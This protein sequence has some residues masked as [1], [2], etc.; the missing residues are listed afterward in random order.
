MENYINS[1]RLNNDF[2]GS[3]ENF[4]KEDLCIVFLKN[5]KNVSGVVNFLFWSYSVINGSIF[6]LFSKNEKK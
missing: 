3:I 1:K 6:F 4:L 5:Y 2:V